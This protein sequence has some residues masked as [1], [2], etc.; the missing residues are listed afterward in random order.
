MARGRRRWCGRR[1]RSDRA[2]VA[3]AH[4]TRRF[5]AVSFRGPAGTERSGEEDPEGVG[6]GSTCDKMGNHVGRQFLL[7]TVP[8]GGWARHGVED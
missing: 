5:S 1:E 4:G 3:C 8:L 7:G 6:E 2:T